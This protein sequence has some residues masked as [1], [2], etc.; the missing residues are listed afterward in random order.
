MLF[1]SIGQRTAFGWGRY[2]LSTM[3]EGYTTQRLLPARSHLDCANTEANLYEAWQHIR[4]NQKDSTTTHT[5]QGADGTWLSRELLDNEDDEGEL[6]AIPPHSLQRQMRELT[7]GKYQPPPLKGVLIPKKNGGVRPLAIPSFRDRVLQ[8]VVARH[9]TPAMEQLMYAGSYGFR[10]GR[11]RISAS[12]AIKAAWD[13]GYH[14]VYESDLKDFFDS[15]NL[16]HLHIRLRCMFGED[17]V[18]TCI[19][20]WMKASVSFQIGRAHV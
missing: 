11:S 7:T 12:Y 20:N 3:E 18:N 9:L 8:R 2:Q 4:K 6:A 5:G 13:E 19:I 15:V 14:W 1:R 17:P 16:E 10:P